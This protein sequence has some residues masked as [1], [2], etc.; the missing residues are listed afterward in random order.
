MQ[1]EWINVFMLNVDNIHVVAVALREWTF[2]RGTF[3]E[4]PKDSQFLPFGTGNRILS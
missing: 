1:F 4:T 3:R 2:I